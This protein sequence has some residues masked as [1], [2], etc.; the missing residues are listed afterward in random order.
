[1]ETITHQRAAE[2]IRSLEDG[3]FFTVVFV[4]RTTGET[5]TM[6]CRQRVRKHLKGGEA[7]YS[8]KEHGLVPVY[9]VQAEG[10]RSI[11]LESLTELRTGGVTYRV[12]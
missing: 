6:N 4:K 9:D 10:Y 2:I 5:R 1:M 11:P 12:R 3:R 7:A 8:F